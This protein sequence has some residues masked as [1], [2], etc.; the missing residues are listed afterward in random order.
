MGFCNIFMSCCTFDDVLVA[1]A[2]AVFACEVPRRP[3]LFGLFLENV[4]RLRW[5]KANLRDNPVP[6]SYNMGNS[7]RF[8]IQDCM[9]VEE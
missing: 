9:D 1:V 7:R 5:N 3:A 2:I 6:H 8:G 4:S